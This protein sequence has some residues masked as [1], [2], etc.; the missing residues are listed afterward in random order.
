MKKSTI[1]FIEIG[2]PGGIITA[3]YV[4][5]GATWL[6]TFL[7]ASCLCFVGGNIMLVK[8]IRKVNANGSNTDGDAGLGL[9]FFECL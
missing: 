9:V 2:M 7:I 1:V 3:G 6:R 5:P 8:E 4:L